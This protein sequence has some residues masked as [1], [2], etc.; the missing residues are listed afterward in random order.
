MKAVD[1]EKALGMI[2]GH[3]M[4][5]I[6]PGEFKGVAF[7]KG[8]VIKAKDIPLLRSMGK[9]HI[10]V[11]EIAEGDLHENVAADQLAHVT[12]HEDLTLTQAAEGKVDIKAHCQGLLKI[13]RNRLVEIN[14]LDGV[15]LATLHNNSPVQ[16]G[17]LIASAKIIPLVIP[18]ETID[19]I[20]KI[21]EQKPLIRII[22]FGVKRAGLIIT[23][24]EVYKG[25]IKDTFEEVITNK[26]KA[27]GSKVAQTVILP[28]DADLI[29]EHIKNF[30]ARYDVV[31]VTG[32]MSVDPD[33]V[34]PVAVRKTGAKVEV[35]GAPVLPGAMFMTAYLGDVPILGIPAC[36]M[37]SKVT[38]L[39]AVLP[40]VLAGETITRKHIASLGHGGLCRRCPDG[41]HYPHCSFVK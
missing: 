22:P 26:F 37:F 17:E 29:A 8:H 34:T 1:V 4:T 19:Q 15:A 12:A 10:Y 25:I 23:G 14:S 5:R 38:I 18:K 3:D 40:K 41:C 32:G 20:T 21:C 13:D 2:L 9:N 39:D 16:S 6:V 36:G 31:F 11:M 33:D 28:D 7:K 24:S 27:F 30:A 35:Y